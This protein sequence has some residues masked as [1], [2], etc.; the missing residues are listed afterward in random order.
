MGATLVTQ[1]LAH[2]SHVSDRAFRVLIR[3]AVTAY[4]QPHKGNPPSIYRHGRE[5]LAMSLRGEKG[6]EQTRYRAVKRALSELTEA[7]AIEHVQA[8]W[9]GQ[10][11]VYRLTLDRKSMGGPTSPPV[12]GPTSPPKGGSKRAE[13]G[14]R[15]DPPREHLGTSTTGDQE[16]QVVDLRTTGHPPRATGEDAKNVI[17][18]PSG[19]QLRGREAGRAELATKAAQARDHID[20]MNARRKAA[21][22][23]N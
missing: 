15:T 17:P 14:G 20:A 7:G 13:K 18:F 9:S 21:K 12:G 22:E 10:N 16:E 5:L 11:A 8:G 4:D 3:M 1:A 6:S 19:D 23:A 2:W